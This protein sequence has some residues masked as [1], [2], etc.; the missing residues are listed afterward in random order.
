MVRSRHCVG[1]LILAGA[2]AGCGGSSEVP[3]E[4]KA[5][6]YGQ[7]SSE[8]MAKEIGIPGPDGV[9]VKP[10]EAKK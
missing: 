4:Q 10:G 1:L 2:L 3:P 8:Q 6:D 7:K 9:M 5:T